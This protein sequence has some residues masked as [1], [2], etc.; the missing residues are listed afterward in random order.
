M[1]V[2]VLG[3]LLV[4][5]DDGAE[6]EV[7]GARLRALLSRLAADPGQ[8]VPVAGLVD[9]LWP[10]DPPVDAAASLQSLVSRLRKALGPTA[11][12]SHPTGYR[13]DVPTDTADVRRRLADHDHA[14][15]L[16][17]W[18]GPAFPD[19]PAAITAHWADLR[20]TAAE[21]HPAPDP[22]L[23]A[24]LVAEHPAR[25]G[26]RAKLVRALHARG[27]QAE[28][29]TAYEQAR[30]WLADELGADPGPD[31]RAAH[32][33]ALRPAQR[34][35]P[36]VPPTPLVGRAD[37]LTRLVDLT[38][39]ARLVTV[40]GFG[41]MG[42]TR[43]AQA[44][45]AR[46]AH[47]VLWVPL[48]SASDPVD[49]LRHAVARG[50][51]TA[52]VLG[53]R[54]TAD[55]VDLLRAATCLLVLDNCEHLLDPTSE[56]V[57][58]LLAAAPDVRVLTTSREALGVPGEALHPLAPLDEDTSVELFTARATA[59]R[60]DFV[61][62]DDARRV[63]RALDGIPLALELAAARLRSLTTAQLAD[64]VDQRLR[65]L[66]R[67]A[68]TA[69]ARH[70]TLRAVV[71]WSW[72][73]LTGPERELLRV[74]AAFPGGAA[75]DAVA[76]V[77]EVDEWVALDLVSS[78]V[79]KSLVVADGER[80]RLLETVREYA[81]G[82]PG[83]DH[84]P[85]HAAHFLA[86]A[87]TA[88]PHLRTGGQLPWLARLDA[89]QANL[90]AA[91]SWLVQTRDG[92]RALRMVA[93]RAWWWVN[94]R[95]RPAEA[96]AWASAV[97]GFAVSPVTRLLAAGVIADELRE[98]A[99][100]LLMC[101]VDAVRWWHSAGADLLGARMR[102]SADPWSRGIG[103]LVR[104]L[105]AYEL[106]AGRTEEAE[107][108]YR[109]ALRELTEV[110]DRWAIALAGVSLSQLLGNRGAHAEALAVLEEA[111]RASAAFGAVEDVLVPLAPLVQFAR[112]RV[113]TGDLVAAQR[114]LDRAHA[115]A[116]RR[117][118][119]L[120]LARVHLAS[121]ELAHAR[122]ERAEAVDRFRAALATAPPDSP[123]QFRST[124]HSGLARAL[125]AAAAGPEH[126]RALDE[127]RRSPDGPAIAL[128]WEARAL[129]LREVGDRDGA[130]A[131]L[132]E[133]ERARGVLALADPE[134]ADLARWAGR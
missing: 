5:A 98:R 58:R 86:L 54:P 37:D 22:A 127:A 82:V 76:E 42:K 130:A 45:A 20:L 134:I 53:E 32:L 89:E 109:R 13:L 73:L 16:A 18:R 12:S 29:L 78:L 103:V 116:T 101:L 84:R 36:P 49:A 50:D 132:D 61:V 26:L 128:A 25:E 122:G 121:A 68:R 31:L 110:G 1:R 9:A 94:A 123:P 52:A 104:G 14:S 70:R 39:R 99:S 120:E 63:C 74:L 133:A 117:A 71:D 107:R 79:D 15:A 114:E 113:R 23:L 108:W 46:G 95:A 91:L 66:D 33:A 112:L 27:R 38:A 125:P 6:I 40:T 124:I 81:A 72:E 19:L 83:P 69:A 55:P 106:S 96:R 35:A 11:V 30:R 87:E 21:R 57:T 41:G 102:E 97:E 75:L 48:E 131:A 129:W 7:R 77:S 8:V 60:P 10:D 93:A 17:L 51:T 67:G 115:V 100:P 47:P 111:R 119:P 90:D 24:D 56:L 64:R 43:L 88:E 126:D 4:T 44:V 92:P 28:A 85:R 105:A 3:P 118:D 2:V 62:T 80:Y 65:L 34:G 59:A